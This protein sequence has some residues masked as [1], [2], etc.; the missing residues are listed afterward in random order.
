MGQIKLEK[1]EQL[2]EILFRWCR[3]SEIQDKEDEK[4]EQ[5]QKLMD[6]VVK[7]FL[8][9][10]GYF[11]SFLFKYGCFYASNFLTNF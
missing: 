5:H 11:L 4:K 6:R 3:E 9:R 1:I 2:N 10:K 7:D 8:D